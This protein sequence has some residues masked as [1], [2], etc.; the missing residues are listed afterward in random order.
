MT[1]YLNATHVRSGST[2]GGV[3]RCVAVANTTYSGTVKKIDGVRKFTKLYLTL[4]T[5][6]PIFQSGAGC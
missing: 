4:I 1:S 3:S 5:F 6:N 2:I